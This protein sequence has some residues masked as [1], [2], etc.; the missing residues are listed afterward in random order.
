MITAFHLLVPRPDITADEFTTF[1]R[2]E[3]RLRAAEAL[4]GAARRYVRT[5]AS[6][7]SPLAA[8]HGEPTVPYVGVD[9]FGFD[10]VGEALAFPNSDAYREAVGDV[11]GSF[12]DLDR[13]AWLV[14]RERLL[15]DGAPRGQAD[16]GPGVKTVV[17]F[18]RAKG[19]AIDDCYWHWEH[20]HAPMAGGS[21]GVSRLAQYAV[22][23]EEHRRVE[24]VAYDA[25][26]VAWWRTEEDFDT[27]FAAAAMAVDM[28]ED[29][30]RFTD[31]ST[32][33]SIACRGEEDW[34]FGD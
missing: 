30:P 16:T 8:M 31:M 24:K 29:I 11:E 9:T 7:E 27:F 17:T 2:N 23:A 32:Y 12:L 34:V 3:Y 4:S 14:T 10:T 15:T 6:G 18:D 5:P 19:Q 21:P 28:A 26:A 33:Y 13:S 20:V 25:I 22:V 1:W